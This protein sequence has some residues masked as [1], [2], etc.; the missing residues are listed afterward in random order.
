M[1][2]PLMKQRPQPP[3][4]H[5]RSRFPL[6]LIFAA[7]AAMA[8]AD[9]GAQTL[10]WDANTTT[11]GA[12]DGS[13]MWNLNSANWWN[14]TADTQWTNSDSAIFGSST[15]GGTVT[16][17]T[18]ITVGNLT[19]NTT[20]PAYTIAGGGFTL[21][22]S[23]TLIS[24][25][26]NGILSANLAGTGGFTVTDTG[27]VTGTNTLVLTGNNN[28]LS[29]AITVSGS[30]S[31]TGAVN[32][33]ISG[34]SS[35]GSVSQIAVDN[36]STLDIDVANTAS[37]SLGAGTTLTIFGVGMGSGGALQGASS[38]S[39]TWAGNIVLGASGARIGGGA[40][41]A[42]TVDGVI[43]QAVSNSSVLFSRLAG[44]TT[45]LNAVNTYTG[46]TQIYGGSATQ[47]AILK[48][49]VNNAINA[50]SDLSILATA[51]V[52]SEVLDL[53][54][55]VL[56]L[57]GLDTSANQ[58]NG[59]QDLSI[60]NNGAS[61]SVLTIGDPTAANT[62]TFSGSIDDG[63]GGLSLV[64]IDANTQILIGNNGYTGATTVNAGSLQLGSSLATGATGLAG[65][66]GAMA[67][68][69]FVLNGGSFVIDNTG[70]SNNSGSRISDSAVFTLNGGA[71]LYKG[72]DQ[73]STNSSETIGGITFGTSA[74]STSATG[75]STFTV[76][77][78]STNTTTV[79]AG[80]FTR[81]AGGATALVNGVN[82]G[83][84]SGVTSS[85]ASILLTNS[86]TLVGTTAALASGIN[87]AATNTQIVPFLL[88]EVSATTGLGTAT[89]T[90]DTFVTYNPTTGLR[91]LSLSEFATAISS[92][93]NV[94]L[95]STGTSGS[96][97][98]INS[99]IMGANSSL[100]I[101]SGVLT[102]T[103]GAVLFTAAAAISGGTFDFGSAEGIITVIAGTG[104]IASKITGTDGVTLFGAG[105]LG[106]DGQSVFTGGLTL[107]GATV[108]PQTSSIQSGGVAT[109]GPFGLGTV[110]FAGS[111]IRPTTT[112]NTPTT[113][114]NSLI[115]QS[116]TIFAASSTNSLTFSGGVTI[117]NGTRTLTNNSG[118]PVIFSGAIGDG[119]QTLGLTFAGAGTTTLSG[120]N[121]Y[122]GATTI[123]AG[124]VIVSGSIAGSAVTVGNSASLSTSAILG[125][126][127]T[128]GNVTTTGSGNPSTSG[129]T[130]D[131]GNSPNVAGI[132]KTGALSATNGANLA[133]E[134]G[135]NTAGGES[136]TG[137]DQFVASG[138]VTL[139]GGNLQLTL[140]GSPTFQTTDELFLIINNSS[141]S[142]TGAFGSVTLNGSAVN[143]SDIVLGDQQFQL[144]YNANFSGSGSDGVANDVALIA[145]VP[146]PS[147]PLML[148]G[149]LGLL[150]LFHRRRLSISSR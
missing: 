10:T 13:G 123:T 89:G 120:V 8:C 66:T 85:T 112:A 141:A 81:S 63:S 109:S 25:T 1:N 36:G 145:L 46:D 12:Q 65:S 7:V 31:N 79:T 146:E 45:I 96:T 40:S 35:L 118:G 129:A 122:T 60:L 61:A 100:S 9:A 41:G 51:A 143:P 110:T 37:T 77:F 83:E 18:N 124:E 21:T 88:G 149:G 107:R 43:S 86:P 94:Y 42:L 142:V 82:L 121:T 47:T 106:L 92:G 93:N 24:G 11:T 116:D 136:A 80:Q 55:C 103:S 84:G 72:S 59:S 113:I 95:T 139:T 119:G 15:A 69:S 26:G 30:S 32:L 147:A 134:I 90:P 115:I 27:V 138:L 127:G 128:V 144:V 67:S 57:R 74:S 23:N 4:S 132:L 70:A 38:I 97:T 108:V 53:N 20:T 101:T 56:T 50:A 34:A 78:D 98:A 76:Q 131:P 137:Y 125:G 140:L 6:A 28:A 102:D 150:G 5:S 19:F 133:F 130:I 33:E 16:L 71:F 73:T 52:G 68:L 114:G 58:L 29:G 104:Q 44:A 14:G 49:G 126:S 2:L 111:Q 17:G 75:Y 99:L 135:G 3:R 62:K 87:T 117:T 91:P 22:L 48:I 148:L 39:A 64:K 105:V 54:G